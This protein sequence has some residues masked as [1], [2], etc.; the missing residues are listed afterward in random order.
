MKVFE[1]LKEA[2]IE[3]SKVVW[4]K[5]AEVV[6]LTLT[7]ILISGI[8]GAYVGALDFIFTK[9]LELLVSR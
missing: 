2:R 4:P 5:R 1:F 6:K 9:L 8:I 3:L 7:V